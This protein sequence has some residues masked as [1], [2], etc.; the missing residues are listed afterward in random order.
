MKNNMKIGLILTLALTAHAYGSTSLGIANDY[1]LFALGNLI[2]TG[3]DSEGKVAVGGN[4][5]GTGT[6]FNVSNVSPGPGMIVGGNVNLFGG[7]LNGGLAYGGSYSNTS[8]TINGSITNSQPID[9]L[10]ARADYEARSAYYASSA[11]SAYLGNV[12]Y[13]NWGGTTLT[14]SN[15]D[16]NV[17]TVDGSKVTSTLSISAPS[18]STVIVNVTGTNNEWK[19]FGF[20]LSGVDKT[21]ILY[22]FY[23]NTGNLKFSGISV[24]GSVLAPTASLIGAN[25]NMEGNV[26]VNNANATG[27]FEYHWQKFSG[28]A[29]TVVPDASPVPEPGTWLMIGAG[30]VGMSRAIRRRRVAL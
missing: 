18:S 2:Q 20:S 4:A 26:I 19:N 25:G 1:N 16:L 10:S 6:F 15:S 29:P 12:T 5:T 11:T 28:S 9:F 22:N 7:T 24:Q 17:F 14:G 23:Q 21:K 27:G 8:F 3:G 30:L 13:F